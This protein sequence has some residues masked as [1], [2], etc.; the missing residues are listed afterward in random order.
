MLAQNTRVLLMLVLLLSGNVRG[1]SADTQILTLDQCL[2]LALDQNPLILSAIHRYEASLARI[3]QATS[4]PVPSLD[5]ESDVQP[6]PF[7]FA[8]AEETYLG[9]SQTF[10]F[11]GKREL[12]GKIASNESREIQED[13]E[14]LKLDI[15]FFVKEAF[16]SLLLAQEQ[17]QYTRR[18]QELSEDFLNKAELKHAAGDVAQVEVLRAKV[19][20]LRAAN[21]VKAAANHISLAKARLNY[22]LARGKYAPLQIKGDLRAPF[23]ELDLEQLKQEAVSLRPEFKRITISMERE[24]FIKD[25]ARLSNYP[26]FDISFAYH[27]M[28]DLPASWAFSVSTPFSFL[29]KKQQKAEFAEAQANILALRREAENLKNAIQL[30]VE[31]A[32]RNSLTTKDQIRLLQDEILPQAEEVYNMFLFSYQEGEIGGIELIESRKT[33]NEA[34]KSYAD[35]L[36]NYARDLAVLDKAVGRKR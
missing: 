31:E 7:N 13:I 21:A 4:V 29:F 35:A 14:I 18:D 3:D 34:R 11:P 33:L 10:E 27:Y 12:R 26:D 6:Q 2:A 15:A 16:Y 17:I 19:E 25:Q 20:A 32:Y 36:F 23:A 1:Q 9:A 24:G 22:L 30:E 8:G 28:K 5:F